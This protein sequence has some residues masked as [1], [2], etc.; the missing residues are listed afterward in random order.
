MS[1]TCFSKK[2]TTRPK[3]M[4]VGVK[5]GLLEVIV[6]LDRAATQ[7]PEGRNKENRIFADTFAAVQCKEKESLEDQSDKLEEAMTV[8]DNTTYRELRDNVKNAGQ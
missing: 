1:V 5:T 2:T 3:E 4:L 7:A 6:H 8:D